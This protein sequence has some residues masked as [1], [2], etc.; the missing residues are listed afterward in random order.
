MGLAMPYSVLREEVL[1]RGLCA[2]CGACELVCP[3]EAIRFDGLQV[4]IAQPSFTDAD[5]GT[6]NACAAVCPGAD[7]ATPHIEQ[8]LFGRTRT[9]QERWL[10]IYEQAYG[11]H[12]LDDELFARS[13]SGGSITALLQASM[14]A[15]DVEA[16]LTMGRR[17]DDRWCASPTLDREPAALVRQAQS[18]YQIAP[19]LGALRP[20]RTSY[21]KTRI[22]MSALP[23]HVQAMRKLQQLDSP[24][25]EWA[26]S[27]VVLLIELACSSGTTPDGTRSLVEEVVG[28]PAETVVEIRY[29]DGA[30]PGGIKILAS[31]GREHR[32]PFW[33]A[34]RH[35]ADAKTHRCLSCGD[36]MSGVADVSVCDGDPNIFEASFSRPAADKHGQILVRTPAGSAVLQHAVANGLIRAWPLSAQATNLGLARKRNRR[37]QYELDG[38]AIPAGPIPG[39][40]ESIEPQPDDQFI[41]APQEHGSS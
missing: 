41:P 36:W 19:Y 16:V 38:A 5:C 13:A 12:A 11:G 29:R 3:A 8:A 20:L 25:G 9:P 7:P 17:P 37:A 18:T 26:R 28:I 4:T 10:G 31:D 40:V 23:C 6:C 32:L 27:S 39:N 15:L 33:R 34:V 35:F 22:A 14:T 21:P 1:D 30:Y 24:E 2:S